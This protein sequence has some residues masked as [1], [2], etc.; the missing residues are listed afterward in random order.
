VSSL[1]VFSRKLLSLVEIRFLSFN[2][3][4]SDFLISNQTGSSAAT[5]YARS[6]GEDW[7]D[8]GK[9]DHHAAVSA[10]SQSA[11]ATES[12]WIESTTSR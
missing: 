10:V 12:G 11:C 8:F 9:I 6:C 1:L 2:S 3:L 4:L 7:D 5:F